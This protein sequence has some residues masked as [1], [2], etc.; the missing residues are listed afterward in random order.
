LQEYNLPGE[1]HYSGEHSDKIS[2]TGVG[3]SQ[4]FATK[5]DVR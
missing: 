4:Y 5:D 3:T 1:G 2:G